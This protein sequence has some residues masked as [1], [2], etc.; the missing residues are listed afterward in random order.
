MLSDD[1]VMHFLSTLSSARYVE[2]CELRFYK[3]TRAQGVAPAEGKPAYL[4]EFAHIAAIGWTN[5][6]QSVQWL[7]GG[8]LIWEN[9]ILTAAHCASDDE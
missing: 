6:D 3:K 5:E 1:N 2:D 4:R 8:S 9:F 7:C